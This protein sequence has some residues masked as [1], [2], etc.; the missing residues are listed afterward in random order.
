VLKAEGFYNAKVFS[1]S[2]ASRGTEV[3][4]LTQKIDECSTTLKNCS[5]HPLYAYALA[6]EK[7]KS[8]IGAKILQCEVMVGG[9]EAGYAG[10]IDRVAEIQGNSY[11]LDIKSGAKMPW[12]AIQLAGYKQ[13]IGKPV[14]RMCVYLK[15]T[16]KYSVFECKDRYDETVWKA[17]LISYKWKQE[18]V[19]K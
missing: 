5:M 12:H 7:F 10:T 17:A 15:N 18:N 4:L 8:E 11:I 13:L 2:T 9:K 14:R 3:H 19:C 6:W 16:G 1:T